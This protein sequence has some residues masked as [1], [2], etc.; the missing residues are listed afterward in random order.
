MVCNAS[1]K[2][3]EAKLLLHLK[4]TVVS[5]MLCN[6]AEKATEAKLLHPQNACDPMVCTHAERPPREGGRVA[7]G[8]REELPGAAG[9][10]RIA[11]RERGEKRGKK[12]SIFS[13]TIDF[14]TVC[15]VN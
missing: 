2:A 14:S 9:R 13:S 11:G 6:A 1:G 8:V 15:C 3:A 12:R 10:R 7:A 4:N 5:S